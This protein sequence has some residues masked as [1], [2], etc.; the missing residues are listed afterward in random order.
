MSGAVGRTTP[1]YD[2]LASLIARFEEIN[3]SKVIVTAQVQD[4]T[5]WEAGFRTHDDLFRSM[6]ARDAMHYAIN[7]N[8]ISV[9]ADVESLD[10]FNKD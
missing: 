9:F 1:H 5:K 2:M 6:K 3:M 8:E 10:V 4:P 7:G